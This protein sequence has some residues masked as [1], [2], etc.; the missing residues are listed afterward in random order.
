MKL[1]CDRRTLAVA[2]GT[3]S[4][5]LA[6]RTPLPAMGMVLLEADVTGLRVTAT[7]LELT[8]RRVAPAAVE[9]EGG[10]AVPGRL[11]AEFVA[12][13]DDEEV[14]LHAPKELLSVRSRSF[15]T[16]LQGVEATEF[17]PC[18]SPDAQAGSRLDV[19]AQALAE[20]I[21]DTH[22]A[23]STDEARPLLTGVLLAVTDD[24][25]TLAATDGYRIAE[26]RIPCKP[27]P[28]PFKVVVPARALAEVGRA[29][30]DQPDHVQL[31]VSPTGN[32]LFAIGPQTEISSRVLDGSYPDYRAVIPSSWS[33]CIGLEAGELAR[34]LRAL[35]VFARDEAHAVRISTREGALLLSTATKEV[36]AAHTEVPA[37][38]EGP[39]ATS[40]LNVRYLLEGLAR[41]DGEARLFLDGALAPAVLRRAGTDGY[42]YL[43]APIRGVG[44]TS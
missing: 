17:P 21:Q 12:A 23:S 43:V 34:R 5:A 11:L 36:G 27:A 42:T 25:L 18:P 41:V 9:E 35:S 32:Q 28:A 1:T 6:S 8:I 31:V 13:L 19:D 26:R 10:V 22:F 2:L 40:A 16:E 7:D 44:G 37:H 30:R 4:R 15:R 3:V 33:T 24:G 39:G 29:F 38:V 14:D 20:A